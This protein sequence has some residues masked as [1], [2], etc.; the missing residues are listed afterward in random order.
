LE[1]INFGLNNDVRLMG[2]RRLD[3]KPR[4]LVLEGVQEGHYLKVW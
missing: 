1:N 3:L 4:F 2:C